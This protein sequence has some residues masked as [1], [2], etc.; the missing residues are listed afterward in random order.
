MIRS[1]YTELTRP[2][3]NATG[4]AAGKRKIL[5]GKLVC[6]LSISIGVLVFLITWLS[7]ETLLNA[8][9]SIPARLWVLVISLFVV[10]H[11]ISALKW[12][13]M[14]RAVGIN[15]RVRL[16]VWAHFSGLFAN[17]CLPSIVGGDFIRAALVVREQK[18]E[19][20]A[21][22]LG[23]LADRLNDVLALLI[24]ASVASL[25]LPSAHTIVSGDA[26][27]LVAVALISCI[28]VSIAVVRF[29]P[30]SMLPKFLR[31]VFCNVNRAMDSLASNPLIA[32]MGLALSLLI[33]AGFV[34]LNIILANAMAIDVSIVLWVFAWPMAKLVALAPISL[35]GIGI[36]EA[37]LAGILSPFGVEAG[38]AVAQSLSWEIVLIFTG[39]ISGIVVAMIPSR[40]TNFY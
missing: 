12:R 10:A 38:L 26:L 8:I 13:L 15:V 30:R 7:T 23:S 32:L 21:I 19:L 36:R 24:I 22:A 11:V 18:G 9:L 34:S 5:S 2:I 20:A 37:A 39:L 29:L 35:G 28:V 31:S 33:Q 27:T 40:S 3:E 17:L 6:R 1:L 25:F 16:S 14:L 4:E